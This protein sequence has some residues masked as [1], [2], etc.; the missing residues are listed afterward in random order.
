MR[1]CQRI[2]RVLLGCV[3]LAGIPATSLSADR[4]WENEQVFGRHKEPPRVDAL[5]YPTVRLA[6]QDRREE[7]PWYQSLNGQW[8]FHWAADPDHRPVDFYRSDYDVS[9]WDQVAVPG[10]WQTQGY[11]V[12]L[13]TNIPYPFQQ[14]P[15]RVTGDP[16]AHYTN[17]Q[18]R[19]PVGS[20]R[21]TFRVPPQWAG[22]QVF[23]QFDGV[24]S[25]FY[26]WVNGQQV[27]YSQE[28]R[29]PAVF[30]I[31]KYVNQQ[32][33]ILAVEV[34]RYSDGSYLEDQDFW[35]LSG[36]YRDV[37]LWSTGNIH[38][39]DFFVRTDLDNEYRNAQLQVE[40]ELENFSPQAAQCS[41][42]IQLLDA[43]EQII[44]QSRIDAVAVE[45]QGRRQVSS[46]SVTVEN[47]AKWT[48]ETP[49][50]Y[51]LV[52]TLEDSAGNIAA[53]SS[54]KIG[55]RTVEIRDGQLLVNGKAVYLKG[56][57]RHEH[58]PETGHTVSRESMLRDIQLMKQFNINAVRTAHYPND[59]RWLA[60]CDEYGLYVIDEANI[61]SHGMGYGRESLAK[62]PRWK[63]AHLDRVERMVERDKNH[64]SA[65]IWSMGNEA[66]NGVNF[67]ACYAWIKERDPSRPIHY[68]RAELADNTDIY[69]PMYAPIEHLLN[70]A[71]KPQRRPLILCEYAHAMGNSVGN[72]QDYWDVIEAHEQLQGGFIWDWVDQG[73][74]ADVPRGIRIHDSARPDRIVDILGKITDEGVVGPVVVSDAADLNCT[75]PFSVEAVVRGYRGGSYCPL[76]SKGDHQYLLRLN[77]GGIDFVIFQQQWVSARVGLDKANLTRGW[78]RI[79]GV[80]DGQHLL[81]YGNGKEVARVAVSGPV[82]GSPFP[83]NIGRNSE[84]T[85]RVCDLPIREA[86]IYGRALSPD[87]VSDVAS[88]K[89]DALLH[90]QLTNVSG[91]SI[92]L[93]RGTRYFAYGGDFGDQPND[94][95]F[96]INGL[97]QPDRRPNPHLYEV[98]KVY[99]SIKVTPEDLARGQ[100]RVHNKYFFTNLDQFEA[101]WVLRCDGNEVAKGWLGRLDV[102]P[103]EDQVVTVPFQL[104]QAAGEYLLT[105]SFILPSD[106]PWAPQ[107]HCVAWD[108]LSVACLAPDTVRSEQRGTWKLTENES[109]FVID[110]GDVQ[111]AI[112]RQRGAL[113]SYR[114]AGHEMLTSPLVPNFWKVP[115]DNQ[116]R[117][118][119]LNRLGAW[120]EAAKNR[121]V[122]SV[123]AQASESKIEV[124]C[125]SVLP[126][127][128]ARY[129]V[130][131][132]VTPGG[133]VTVRCRY[134]PGAGEIP[135]IPKFGMTCALAGQP[136]QVTWYGRGPQE[137]YWD[138]KTGGEIAIHQLSVEELIHPYVRP[139]DNANRSDVRW[140]TLCGNDGSGIKVS[141]STPLNFSAWPYTIDDLERAR[142]D[143]ELPRRESITLH[144]D[145]QLHGVGGDD[146]WG[147]RTHPQYTLPGNQP[148]EYRFTLS[149]ILSGH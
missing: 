79:T 114:V 141:G 149:P 101:T 51:T 53:V 27:G 20:Y 66:G 64:A 1:R 36:L 35:R 42:G 147:A 86:L 18:Q 116:Y 68:E 127:G 14:D 93:G 140:F 44:L 97:V 133:D 108:Q 89:A 87:E 92:A 113:C 82:A 2:A 145:H 115:N 111:L 134:E 110:A 122:T 142:H 43:Q 29:T 55:F 46:T 57:N 124:T 7:S 118:D 148:Y 117:N 63:A 28:S 104:P 17:A 61:E 75:G 105:V 88:R 33:N 58:D 70:Y 6:I 91:E 34:Y 119:Y 9:K 137:T 65:I 48:A 19:N 74:L 39:R 71:S 10:N 94:G 3:V 109:R 69:C 32:E 90:V 52:L 125:E 30:N 107:G 80:Y 121:R 132:A 54:H 139:Q 99:Q 38:L 85:D 8:F 129:Q 41:V 25:A 78:N 59:V 100:I 138:R 81:I 49:H 102:P 13:Y 73:L 77:N 143:Y 40:M 120:R 5:A 95:N 123:T 22:R 26:L 60:L 131:Y 128:D 98:R 136:N 103:Q 45:P 130:L 16:P 67:E 84:M 146:S 144:I 96:C 56:V 50:L 83:V 21:R 135:L 62:D 31:T 126:V 11:G 76:I 12:P 47:P 4:D 23:L 15:P 37:F 112:D 106:T 24:D 72:L